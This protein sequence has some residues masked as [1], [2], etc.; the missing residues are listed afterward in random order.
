MGICNLELGDSLERQGRLQEAAACYRIAE[1][2]LQ[3]YYVRD[4]YITKDAQA[5]LDRICKGGTGSLVRR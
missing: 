2:N 3:A 4:V 1:T 5:R